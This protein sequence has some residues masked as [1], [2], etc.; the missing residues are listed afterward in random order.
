MPILQFAGL[1]SLSSRCCRDVYTAQPYLF[2]TRINNFAEIIG[3]STLT[4]LDL[5]HAY[6]HWEKEESVSV[7][8]CYKE[9][10]KL[11]IA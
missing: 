3:N 6:G 4:T 1:Y 8:R 9:V 7:I 5:T 2:R 10:G 11:V